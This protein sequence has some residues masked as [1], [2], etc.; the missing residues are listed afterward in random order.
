VPI[1]QG[2]ALVANIRLSK[3][4][5]AEAALNYRKTVLNALQEVEDG[6]DGLEHDAQR[7][8]SLKDAL[9]AQE[10]ALRV[11]LDAYRHGLIT[12]IAVLTV[13]IQEVQARQQ[14]AEMLLMQSTDLIKLYKALG[15]G[16]EDI[17]ST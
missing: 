13:Q 17:P 15:G 14:L 12:Y 2:G 1:F 8:A 9:D 3:A 10:R 16:W 6:L 7:V 11:D 4:Q 5:A